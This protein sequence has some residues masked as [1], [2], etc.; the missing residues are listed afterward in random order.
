VAIGGLWRIVYVWLQVAQDGTKELDVIILIL[1]QQQQISNSMLARV[2]IKFSLMVVLTFAGLA[3]LISF[4][5][6]FC[7]LLWHVVV[8]ASEAAN[9]SGVFTQVL[10]I[11]ILGYILYRCLPLGKHVVQFLFQQF[12]F[13]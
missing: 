10:L 5:V 2:A 1:P 6:F 3:I 8:I 7:M 11:F 13:Q 12:L 9:T 4:L